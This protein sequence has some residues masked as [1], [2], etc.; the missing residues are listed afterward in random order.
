MENLESQ[1]FVICLIL[2]LAAVIIFV[3]KVM[4]SSL[5]GPDRKE[6]STRRKKKAEKNDTEVR[7]VRTVVRRNDFPEEGGSGES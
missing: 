4:L 7:P 2:S 6:K 3:Y 5:G 1:L